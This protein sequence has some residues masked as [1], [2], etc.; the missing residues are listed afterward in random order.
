MDN[1]SLKA[2]VRE[3]HSR[4]KQVL[5]LQSQMIKGRK[6]EQD[7]LGSAFDE[8]AQRLTRLC[9]FDRIHDDKMNECVKVIFELAKQIDE[10]F[11]LVVRHRLA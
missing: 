9:T 6:P 5:Q 8:Q 2:L 7:E 3:L 1:T 11:S 4:V 10:G